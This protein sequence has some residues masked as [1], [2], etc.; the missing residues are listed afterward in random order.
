LELTRFILLSLAIFAI[1]HLIRHFEGPFGILLKFR[2]M[3][4]LEY[5][6]VLGIDNK[7]VGIVEEPIDYNNKLAC[8]VGCHWCI[9][10]WVALAVMLL[11][12]GLVPDLIYYWFA[13]TAISG[14]LYNHR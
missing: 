2:E 13:A 8:F 9:T 7:Q 1:T 14:M 12:V 11:N 4:G 6:P 10:T 5:T 3:C